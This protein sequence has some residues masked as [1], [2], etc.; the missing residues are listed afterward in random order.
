MNSDMYFPATFFLGC[1]TYALVVDNALII[2][3]FMGAAALVFLLLTLR[4]MRKGKGNDKD[5]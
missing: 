5:R 1:L 2:K 4:A 3:L